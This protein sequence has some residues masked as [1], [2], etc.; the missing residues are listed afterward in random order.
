KTTKVQIDATA[1]SNAPVLALFDSAALSVPPSEVVLAPDS[2]AEADTNPAQ[3][4]TVTGSWVRYR[5]DLSNLTVS[6]Q[7]Q[8]QINNQDNVNNDTPTELLDPINRRNTVVN[9]DTTTMQATYISPSCGGVD[10]ANDALYR[11]VP[12]ASQQVRISTSYP[13]TALHP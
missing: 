7:P 9:A 8:T 12:S 1:S 4:P 11:F 13:Q 10:S 2:P 6:S 3:T 5:G